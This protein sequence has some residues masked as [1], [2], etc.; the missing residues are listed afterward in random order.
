MDSWDV[1]W[2]RSSRYAA[3]EI[4]IRRKRCPEFKLQ[5]ASFTSSCSGSRNLLK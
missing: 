3:M 2:L 4:V 5:L 1:L